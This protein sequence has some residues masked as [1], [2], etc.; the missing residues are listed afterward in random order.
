MSQLIACKTEHGIVMGADSKAVDVDA[1][2][3]LIELKI[4][5][6]HTLSQYSAMLNGGAA[7]GDRRPLLFDQRAAGSPKPVAWRTLAIS[8]TWM[9]LN[10]WPGFTTR[11]D[12]P[13][14]S[15]TSWLLPGP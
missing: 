13:F 4:D 2:G 14:N 3:N 9:R 15:E 1:N 8:S 6:V 5:R 11:R 7:A 10:T 12:L